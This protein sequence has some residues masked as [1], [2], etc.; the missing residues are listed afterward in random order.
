MAKNDINL[1]GTEISVLKAI[2][3]MGAEISGEELMARAPDL[4]E[5]E[6]IDTLKGLIMMG[7]VVADRRAFYDEEGLKATNFYVNS[8]YARDL[9]EAMDPRNDRPKSKRVRRE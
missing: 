8:G 6:L 3:L 4:M 2:G 9:K 5:A 1:D 7:Y